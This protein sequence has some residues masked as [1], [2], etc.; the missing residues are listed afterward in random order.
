MLYVRAQGLHRP[1]CAAPGYL[2]RS[3]NV[4]SFGRSAACLCLDSYQCRKPVVRREQHYVEINNLYIPFKVLFSIL[5]C[6]RHC[7]SNSRYLSVGCR[8]FGFARL[9]LKHFRRQQHSISRLHSASA[10]IATSLLKMRKI[11]EPQSL[12]IT[13]VKFKGLAYKYYISLITRS[14]QYTAYTSSSLWFYTK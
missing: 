5:P 1:S 14:I 9:A 2:Y 7:Y 3:V 8:S 12:G 10:S 4:S 6:L 13:T 11:T